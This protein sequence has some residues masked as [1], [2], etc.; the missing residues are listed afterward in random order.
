MK[1]RTL[2]LAAA[3]LPA[4]CASP[5]PRL[6]TLRAVPGP[7]LTGG[8]RAITLRQVSLARYLE[9]PQIVRSSEDYRLDVQ[10][11]DWWGE[12]LAAM[13]G[14]VLG[15]DLTQ[16]LPGTQVFNEAGAI[17]P[18]SDARIEVNVLRLDADASGAVVLNAQVA[19]AGPTGEPT[20]HEVRLT[21]RPTDGTLESQVAAT[22]QAVGQLADAI[23]AQVA[24]GGP[25]ASGRP[26]R[27]H[28]ARH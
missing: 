26:A 25:A 4:A 11:N 21:V 14:R 8:P 2:L 17:S 7:T 9:R 1:R 16:R 24:R 10:A 6:Y 13:V 23:A 15:E 20:A 12:P 5:D 18:D 3:L 22:S 27:R 28:R 19:I